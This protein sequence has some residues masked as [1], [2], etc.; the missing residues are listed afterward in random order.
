VN[1]FKLNDIE[2]RNFRFYSFDVFAEVMVI[3]VYSCRPIAFAPQ[4]VPQ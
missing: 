3:V 1:W 2:P 4:D